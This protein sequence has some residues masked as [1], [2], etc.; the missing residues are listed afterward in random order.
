M[1]IRC[2]LSSTA[3]VSLIEKNEQHSTISL[4]IFI[5]FI[6]TT[7]DMYNNRIFKWIGKQA[8]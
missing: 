7:E 1:A 8:M 4:N 6:V 2:T 5:T 3:E